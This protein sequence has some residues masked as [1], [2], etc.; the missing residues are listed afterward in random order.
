MEKEGL[1]SSN[2]SQRFQCCN[3]LIVFPKWRQK[4]NIYWLGYSFLVSW[5]IL[6][7]IIMI[8]HTHHV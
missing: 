5:C 6:H 4:H 1:R 8:I 3:L 2:S 7:L